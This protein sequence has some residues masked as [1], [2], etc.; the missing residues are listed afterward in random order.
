MLWKRLLSAV[1]TLFSVLKVPLKVVS[2]RAAAVRRR[3]NAYELRSTWFVLPD[4][5]ARPKLT[6]PDQ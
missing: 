3:K 4:R 2:Q 6:L 1:W 5:A